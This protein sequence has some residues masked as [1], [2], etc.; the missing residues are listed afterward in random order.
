MAFEVRFVEIPEGGKR[1]AVHLFVAIFQEYLVGNKTALESREAVE[2]YL[3]EALTAD[4][5]TDITD[6]LTYINGGTTATLK[7]QRLDEIYRVLVLAEHDT[8]YGTQALL[9]ARLSWI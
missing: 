1:M 8:W 4:E 6:S 3:G 5:I 2:A 9:K 7:R